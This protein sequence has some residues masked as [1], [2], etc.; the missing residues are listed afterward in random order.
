MKAEL[1]IAGLI[2][3]AGES[4]RM[5]TL[6]ALLPYRGETFL[7]RLIDVFSACCRSVTVVLGAGAETIRTGIRRAVQARFVINEN[8]RLGQ[9]T[10]MQCGLRALPA[11]A[12]GVLFTLVDHPDVQPSTLEQLIA[13]PG[14]LLAIPRYQGRRGHPI[15][16]KRELGAEFLALDHGTPARD[17][18]ERHVASAR[19]IDV[20]DPGI[21][22][23][24]D[25][26][27]AYRRLID[28]QANT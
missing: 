1:N 25:E 19:Y 28:R 8:Y 27:E 10:S 18:I 5:G 6:K 13:D 26:P 3:A 2:L 23:D 22:S 17:V 12:E 16:F 4:R 11:E 20:A 21:L 24:V 9:I 7:D 15:Y 14:A